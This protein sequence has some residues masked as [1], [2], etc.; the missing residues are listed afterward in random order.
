M[1]QTMSDAGDAVEAF[2][3]IDLFAVGGTRFLEQARRKAVVFSICED[4]WEE[5]LIK[6]PSEEP[7]TANT[8]RTTTAA[9]ATTNT[10]QRTRQSSPVSR[11]TAPAALPHPG[12]G[13]LAPNRGSAPG[14]S[15]DEYQWR[16]TMAPPTPRATW[17]EYTGPHAHDVDFFGKRDGERRVDD[18]VGCERLLPSCPIAGPRKVSEAAT[19]VDN[20]P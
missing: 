5:M 20:A 7:S 14:G 9:P 11:H 10:P 6:G 15:N 1:L 12:K 18:G 2:P 4:V 8:S 17:S 13:N 16:P 19:A 3:S